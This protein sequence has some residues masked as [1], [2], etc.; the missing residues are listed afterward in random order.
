LPASPRQLLVPTQGTSGEKAFVGGNSFFVPALKPERF[1]SSVGA[2]DAFLAG[3]LFAFSKGLDIKA[4]LHY[5]TQAA[6]AILG[7]IGAR[8]TKTLGIDFEKGMET[9]LT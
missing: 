5:G 8:P 1:V 9:C 7:E 3:F 2:G 6:V 4:S